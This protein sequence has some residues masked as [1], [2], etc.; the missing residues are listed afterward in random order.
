M[1]RTKR[2]Y[3]FGVIAILC[4]VLLTTCED[5][6]FPKA[7][8]S[9]TTVIKESY[10]LHANVLARH[11]NGDLVHILSNTDRERIRAIIG[12]ALK[13]EHFSPQGDI[14]V[15]VQKRI[16]FNID[17]RPP[18]NDKGTVCRQYLFELVVH[19][20]KDA[21]TRRILD[22][23]ILCLSQESHEWEDISN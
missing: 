8:A 14:W 13:E 3:L 2:G 15:G 9:G 11:M 4:A 20:Y 10:P 17:L 23:G 22:T 19:V 7:N 18:Y 6:L 12:T 1:E 16:L 21:A 5:N